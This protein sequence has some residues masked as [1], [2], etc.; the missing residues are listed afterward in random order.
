[1]VVA[2]RVHIRHREKPDNNFPSFFYS[3]K[4]RVWL[5]FCSLSCYHLRFARRIK[6]RISNHVCPNPQSFSTMKK[7]QVLPPKKS[8]VLLMLHQILSTVSPLLFLHLKVQVSLHV[9]QVVLVDLTNS[10]KKAAVGLDR[11][12]G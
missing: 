8:K 9:Q 4:I 7:R 6:F 2:P 5:L 11:K 3:K 1:M 10:Q 12:E